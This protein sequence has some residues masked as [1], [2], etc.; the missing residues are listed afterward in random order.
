MP[1]TYPP[2]V[3]QAGGNTAGATANIRTG[4]VLFAGGNNIT[5]SQNVNSI[6]ISGATIPSVTQYFSNTNT[7]FNG[8]NV[9]GSIT[10]NTNGLQINLSVNAGAGAA[11]SI[12]A[13]TT[14]ATL[15]EVVFANSNGVS[16]GV[17][18][19]TVTASHNG[20]TSQTVQ[21]QGFDNTLGMSNLGNT[22]GT[23]GVISGTGLQYLFAGGA[24]ITLSQSINGQS[25]TLS[26]SGGAG[27]GGDTFS[28][29][30]VNLYNTN[31][32]QTGQQGNGTIH[33]QRIALHNVVFDGIFN[34][35]FFTNGS[36]V[37]GS[38]TV[39]VHMGFYTRTSLSLSIY[40]STSQTYGITFSGTTGTLGSNQLGWRKWGIQWTSTLTQGDYYLAILTR[41]A[42]AGANCSISQMLATKFSNS[43]FQ[44]YFGSQTNVTYQS[45][46]LAG[47]YSTSSTNLPNSLAGQSIIG[48]GTLGHRNPIWDAAL[49]SPYHIT[50]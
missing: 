35:L 21:T 16:F 4:T 44:G 22:S 11:G 46:F 9:S 32:I 8:T 24:N 20:I 27:G 33:I 10:L 38:A 34:H 5:L 31:E 19:Q 42:S 43:A 37:T 13:G 49:S 28:Y 18:G 6:T 39:S 14:K 50:L 45:D 15:G 41:T 12:S 36:A 29:T 2:I 26:I 25:A 47:V 30:G 3:I 7:T 40:A 1:I 17:N 48:T 23:S